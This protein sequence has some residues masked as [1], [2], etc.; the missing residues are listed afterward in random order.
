MIYARLMPAVVKL[1]LR[2]LKLTEKGKSESSAIL[3]I[4]VKRR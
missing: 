1:E 3:K 2:P 4:R